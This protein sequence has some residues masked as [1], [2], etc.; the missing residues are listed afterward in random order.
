LNKSEPE[1][2]G[3][4]KM[5]GR[6]VDGQGGVAPPV[7]VPE[8]GFRPASG[9]LRM[10]HPVV[11]EHG[12]ARLTIHHLVSSGVGTEL[13]VEIS[14]V[15]VVEQRSGDQPPW[16]RDEL[17]IRDEQGREY[18][19]LKRTWSAGGQSIPRSGLSTL[20]RSMTLEP[21]DPRSRR[22]ELRI[23]GSVGQWIAPIDLVPFDP[24]LAGALLETK[25]ARH[26]ITITLQHVTFGSEVTALDLQVVAEPPVRSV[27]GL[28]ALFGMRRGPSRLVLKDSHGR[29]Y[30][31]VDAPAQR[32]RDPMGRVDVAQFV[33]VPPDA[34]TLELEVPY[35]IVEEADGVAEFD[36]PVTEPR[37][38]T[39]G[40]YPIRVL[41]S[42]RVVRPPE[43]PARVVWDGLSLELDLGSWQGERRLLMP[44]RVPVD[45]QDH[46]YRFGPVTPGVDEPVKHLE[47]PLTDPTSAQRISFRYPTVQVRGPWTL[48]FPRVGP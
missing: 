1:K 29:F 30:E 2:A 33:A 7:L 34:G 39:F 28:G 24:A 22:V 4:E 23:D 9:V 31:E 45:G 10:A 25:V 40:A 32:P 36:L 3:E 21:L 47:I 12:S 14:G 6:P 8:V 17:K 37:A 41:A 48:R 46:G 43:V 15:A 13:A 38:L 35:V 42:G 11:V 18:G 19:P 5:P 16:L 27:R 26:G 44:G 20:Q